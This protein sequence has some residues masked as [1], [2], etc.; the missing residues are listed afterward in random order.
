VAIALQTS[1]APIP[2]RPTAQSQPSIQHDMVS[3]TLLNKRNELENN[4]HEQRILQM[5]LSQSLINERVAAN[6]LQ[7]HQASLNRSV[8]SIENDTLALYSTLLP[9]VAKQSN[10]SYTNNMNDDTIWQSLGFPS[11][12]SAMCYIARILAE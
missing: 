9:I 2:G 5:S 6:N 8:S 3:A 11:S 12:L 10:I 4:Q 1:D 7:I